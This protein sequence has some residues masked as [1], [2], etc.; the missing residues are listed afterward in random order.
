MSF[1]GITG[2]DNKLILNTNIC[3]KLQ[4]YWFIFKSCQANAIKIFSSYVTSSETQ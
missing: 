3:Q 4:K 2:S 1:A